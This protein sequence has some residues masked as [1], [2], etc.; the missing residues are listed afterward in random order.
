MVSNT[1]HIGTSHD[2]SSALV[3]QVPDPVQTQNLVELEAGIA[4][5]ARRVSNDAFLFHFF[6]E[7]CDA[8][9]S[10][11][12][13]GGSPSWMELLSL[14][15]K[16]ELSSA[17]TRSECC[18]PKNLIWTAHHFSVPTSINRIHSFVSRDS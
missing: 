5:L 8:D 16:V 15:I 13:H 9:A 6:G 2:H 14:K 11:H 7:Y 12:T 10:G 4:A 1:K 18:Q 17:G 3:P